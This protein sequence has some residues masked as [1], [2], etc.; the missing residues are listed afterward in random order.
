MVPL[1]KTK[2]TFGAIIMKK[3]FIFLSLHTA[4][5]CAGLRNDLSHTNLADALSYCK[6]II[7]HRYNS[8]M[9]AF[10]TSLDPKE[11]EPTLNCITKKS[12]KYYRHMA[13]FEAFRKHEFAQIKKIKK[14][15]DVPKF[16]TILSAY[17]MTDLNILAGESDKSKNLI[18][19]L[20]KTQTTFGSIQLQKML[21]ELTSNTETIAKR[22]ELLNVLLKNQD[23]LT[24][25]DAT[26][27]KIGSLEN[28]LI[29]FWS[30]ITERKK[31]TLCSGIIDRQEQDGQRFSTNASWLMT[32]MRLLF[33]G[34][35]GLGLIGSILS[36][37]RVHTMAKNGTPIKE[38]LGSITSS[39]FFPISF[40]F[41]TR[42]Q[43]KAHR[44]QFYA[45]TELTN[46]CSQ[47]LA[48]AQEIL[49]TSCAQEEF[50]IACP[51]LKKELN[52]LIDN[53]SANKALRGLQSALNR[54]KTSHTNFA[55]YYTTNA[56]SVLAAYNHLRNDKKALCGI[57]KSIGTIDA[58]VTMA[59]LYKESQL[60]N[61]RW[62][63]VTIE[64]ATTPHLYLENT[65]N[66]MLQPDRAVP[67]S[68]ELGL[69]A[70]GRYGLI[71]GPN[72]AG[73]STLM[74]CVALAIIFAQTFGIAPATRASLTPFAQIATYLNISDDI[75]QGKSRFKMEA[76]RAQQLV[77]SI[78]KLPQ[79]QFIFA[80]M[81]ETF[82][83]TDP[84]EG[85]A[86]SYSI[87]KY[88]VETAPQ[89]VILAAT[90]Y[91]LLKALEQD[92]NGLIKN[93]KV[94]ANVNPI[95]YPFNLQEGISNKIIA[96]EILQE[97]GMDISKELKYV[98][99]MLEK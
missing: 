63:F 8:N 26:L 7:N 72:A 19:C 3:L 13:L 59:K 56:G 45:I 40:I 17:A 69:P 39:L 90:H 94:E 35:I 80:L 49:H 25:L 73:K 42:K 28:S 21:T 30:Q 88:L 99:E 77:Q 82:S 61:N 93:Y 33:D 55:R 43:Y 16:E 57:L 11:K 15:E 51:Q 37:K 60:N 89:S 85:A 98:K 44:E 52:E 71:G 46:D 83:G 50:N 58:Y 5:F 84:R 67:S 97:E 70:I 81:D 95:S 1:T 47:L 18:S 96:L 20:P 24:E 64:S 22:Q 79:G 6:A 65:W 31:M 74:R 27:Q 10:L 62:T 14:T 75:M 41:L 23:L 78:E 48:N 29:S 68:I 32:K 54:T 66:P 38:Y 76:F 36:A 9:Q 92:T 2:K 53:S 34:A 91:P 86:A 87:L 12:N 4:L